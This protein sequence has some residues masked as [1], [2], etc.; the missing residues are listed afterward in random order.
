MKITDIG[1]YQ[2]NDSISGEASFLVV[3]VADNSIGL[4]LS[5][6]TNGDVEVFLDTNNCDMLI[7]WLR[8][9][10]SIAKDSV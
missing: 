5:Q 8:T 10:L 3:R 6:R 7:Q 4:G 2:F 1:S 9:A